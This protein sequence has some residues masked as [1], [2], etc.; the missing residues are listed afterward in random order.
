MTVVP[1]YRMV[2]HGGPESELTMTAHCMDGGCLWE[3]EPTPQPGTG[4]AVGCE[5][6][7]AATGHTTFAVCLEFIALVT[8]EAMGGEGSG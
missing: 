8:T 4:G 6:H 7:T 3:S 5:A 2:R 1:V